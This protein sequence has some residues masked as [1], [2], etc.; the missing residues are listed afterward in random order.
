MVISNKLGIPKLPR[1]DAPDERPA[2]R[3]KCRAPAMEQDEYSAME[4]K[5][6]QV[7]TYSLPCFFHF[8]EL[9][10]QQHILHDVKNRAVP[11]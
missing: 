10:N 6:R 11:T 7:L 1:V 8:R 3:R 2:R 5:M 9:V 4:M